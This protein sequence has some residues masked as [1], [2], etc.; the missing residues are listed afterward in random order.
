MIPPMDEL[1]EIA[2][3]ILGT[4]NRNQSVAEAETETETLSQ[5]KTKSESERGNSEAAPLRIAFYNGGG[6]F[7]GEPNGPHAQ[8]FYAAVAQAATTLSRRLRTRYTWQNVT[9]DNIATELTVDRFDVPTLQ[10]KSRLSPRSA[11][12]HWIRRLLTPVNK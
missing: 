10:K 8:E 9:E 11:V 3:G 12:I 5:T 2:R 6:T 4:S 1:L 7:S